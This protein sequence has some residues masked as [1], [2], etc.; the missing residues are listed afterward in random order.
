MKI[1]GQIS[2]SHTRQKSTFCI[3]CTIYAEK[4]KQAE[5]KVRLIQL[6]TEVHVLISGLHYN[7]SPT[8]HWF[9]VQ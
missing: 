3:P 4:K 5:D 2:G 7:F 1:Q 6:Q 9:E 8:L